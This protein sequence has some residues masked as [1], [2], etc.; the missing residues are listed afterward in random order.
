MHVDDVAVN[1]GTGA[2]QNSWPGA[3]Q[4]LLLKPTSDSARTGW[5]GGA[6][7]T[8]NLWDAV[9]NTPP[10]GVAAA[11]ETN[12]S[13][14]KDLVSSA[15]NNYDATLTDYTTAGV[16]AGQPVTLVQSVIVGGTNPS[17]GGISGAVQVVSN[18]AQSPED[19]FTYPTG[20]LAAWPSGWGTRW[21]TAQVGD[22]A[23]GSRSTSPVLRVGKRSA[24]ATEV[25]VCFM[26]LMVEFS[27]SG[28]PPLLA[29]MGVGR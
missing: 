29:L 17:T 22:I 28:G 23:A 9:N 2:T 10:A 8:T 21:G 25:D 6:G 13:Q 4:I 7:G 27:A 16:P 12:T 19:T 24:V 5:T 3:G 15:T 20:T 1:Y 11:S 26:G 18:P 14:I